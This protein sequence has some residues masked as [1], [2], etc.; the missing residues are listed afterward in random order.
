MYHQEYDS[1]KV[2]PETQGRW[3]PPKWVIIA[4]IALAAISLGIVCFI[5][6]TQVLF[7]VFGLSI[8]FS[9]TCIV[10]VKMRRKQIVLFVG[11]CFGALFL[12]VVFGYLLVFRFPDAVLIIGALSGLVIFLTAVLPFDGGGLS[13]REPRDHF[14][15]RL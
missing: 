15:K 1:Q 13:G 3:K 8:F 5:F 9:W 11:L 4:A 12:A 14:S 2:Y 6:W 10:I 7:I